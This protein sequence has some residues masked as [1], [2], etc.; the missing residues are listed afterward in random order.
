MPGSL[1][2]VR[3]SLLEGEADP[4]SVLLRRRRS[5]YTVVVDG[6]SAAHSKVLVSKCHSSKE[7]LI[8]WN[9]HLLSVPQIIVL[10]ETSLKWQYTKKHFVYEM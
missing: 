10:I 8:S 1:A 3:G 2:A 5:H 7:L 9:H 6:F 4:C